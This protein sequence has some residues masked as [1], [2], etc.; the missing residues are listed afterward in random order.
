MMCVV[1]IFSLFREKR[2]RLLEGTGLLNSGLVMTIGKSRL[3][4]DCGEEPFVGRCSELTMIRSYGCIS[5]S[6]VVQACSGGSTMMGCDI[7]VV[8]R[9]D[10]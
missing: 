5:R 3:I 9:N 7:S 2:I 8:I 1:K 4:T 10:S 6:F